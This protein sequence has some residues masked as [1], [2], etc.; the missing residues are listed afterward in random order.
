VTLLIVIGGIGFLLGAVLATRM[1]RADS[2]LEQIIF[3]EQLHQL[4]LDLDE[5]LRR[6]Q[7]DGNEHEH[8]ERTDN[9]S[10]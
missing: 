7:F 2:L 1:V 10:E 5:Q 3:D 6:L 8:H 9:D 4:Q